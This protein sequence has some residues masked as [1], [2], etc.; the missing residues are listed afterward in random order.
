MKKG[1]RK[2]VIT[3]AGMV[4][5]A[6]IAVMSVLCLNSD[7]GAITAA[8]TTTGGTLTTFAGAIMIGYSQEYK[9]GSKD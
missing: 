8:I 3:I 5:I 1:M 6:G 9:H 7:A 2:F 4:I